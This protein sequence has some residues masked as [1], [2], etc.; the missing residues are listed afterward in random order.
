MLSAKINAFGIVALLLSATVLQLT[1][2]AAS[3]EVKIEANILPRLTLYKTVDLCAGE[4]H[5]SKLH[6][7]AAKDADLALALQHMQE[8]QVFSFSRYCYLLFYQ[9][10]GVRVIDFHPFRFQSGDFL[11]SPDPNMPSYSV[12]IDTIQRRVTIGHYVK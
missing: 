11:G 7:A 12:I 5:I 2:A 8:K 6:Q 4:F 10:E 1:T 9:R 3:K